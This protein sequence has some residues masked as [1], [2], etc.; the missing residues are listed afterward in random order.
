MRLMGVI[1]K[2][3]VLMQ[4]KDIPARVYAKYAL[5]MIPGTVA[6]ILILII[7][8]RWV[9]M[10]L[11]L[12]AAIVFV[13]LIKDVVMFPFVWRSYDKPASAISRSMIGKC[14]VAK[15]PLAPTGYIQIQGELW[16]AEKIHNCPPIERGESVRVTEMQGLKLFVTIENRD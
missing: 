13:W 5:L 10:P 2:K 7:A 9:T 16:R 11:W 15:E 6:V 12:N 1:F 14:G 3:I 8:R 4:L